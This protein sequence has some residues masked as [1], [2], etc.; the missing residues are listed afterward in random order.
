VIGVYQQKGIQ[1]FDVIQHALRKYLNLDAQQAGFFE[2][3]AHSYN[4]IR[5]QYD[6]STIISDLTK[7]SSHSF[8]LGLGVVGVDIYAHGMNFIFGMAETLKKVALVSTY[9]LTGDKITERLSKEVVHEIGHLL[10]LEHCSRPSC[11]MH[12]SNTLDDTD[13]KNVE[14]CH[15]CRIKIE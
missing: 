5:Q 15:N 8:T 4:P 13:Y 6:A 3:T 7:Q 14:L 12:F 9:R 1:F 2:L 11:V 10:G